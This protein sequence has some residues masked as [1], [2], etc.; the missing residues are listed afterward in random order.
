[1]LRGV[2]E[3]KVKVII[4]K[5]GFVQTVDILER[6]V[7]D[8]GLKV[9]S[10]IDAQANLKKI[11]VESGGNKILEVFNPKLAKEVFDTNLKAGIVPPLKTHIY[12]ENDKT[13]VMTQ[14]AEDLFS[15]YDGL[16][17]LGRRVDEILDSVLMPVE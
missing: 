9:I 2:I 1:M 7:N 4:S 5:Y 8:K 6:S 13:N 16:K 12:E 11:G 14:S 3:M 10:V 15:Q 17:D